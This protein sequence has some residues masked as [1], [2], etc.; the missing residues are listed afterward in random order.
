M[1]VS[2]DPAAATKELLAYCRAND[3]AGHDPYDA[4]NSRLLSALPFL[5]S[6]LPRLILTQALKRSP[7]NIRRFAL[8]PPTQNPK[9]IALFL[10][11]LIR[12]E[13]AGF[14]HPG[15]ATSMFERLVALRSPD[16]RH[17]CW[18][19]SFPWQ[20]RT[21][22]VPR[23]TPN[24]VC[25]T[26]VANALLDAYEQY[27]ESRCLNMAADAAEYIVNE[28]LWTNGDQAGFSYPLPSDR[29][30]I[31]NANFLGSALL[32]RVSRLTGDR[33]L[34]GPALQVAR[35][36]A[37]HQH[38][39]GSWAYGNGPHQ[40]WI[41]NFHTGY[42]L[43]ALRSIGR[44]LATSEFDPYVSRGFAFYC[45][46]FFREDG[47]ARYFHDRT[48]PIDVHSVAQSILTLLAFRDIDS[49]SVSL[50]HEVFR[51][52]MEHLWD[53]RGFFYYRVLRFGTIRTSYMRW[54]QAWMLLALVTLW[55]E[56]RSAR[57]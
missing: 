17:W 42:N 38:A 30:Q 50:A 25:T 12:M 15:L 56:S 37:L 2:H 31:H 34:V 33:R 45:S 47:A 20:T 4:L 52:A 11:A 3:W 39:D 46:H 27:H 36:S 54:S 48:Y 49:R 16:A 8:I 29:T 18:G 57:P 1:N 14:E 10:A 41:D 5:D 7:I 13:R 51:W 9:G 19:Y 35:C 24:L 21:A 43:C 22:V 55:T 44:D 32:C 6:R 23:W 28:L 53:D 40:Q 26:F